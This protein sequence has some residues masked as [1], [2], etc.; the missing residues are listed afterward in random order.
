MQ[1][2]PLV[3]AKDSI[4]WIHSAKRLKLKSNHQL[5][6]SWKRFIIINFERPE[7]GIDGSMPGPGI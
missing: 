2:V 4:N 7:L 6:N 5:V 1:N 3:L